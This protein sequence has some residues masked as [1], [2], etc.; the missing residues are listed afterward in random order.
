MAKIEIENLF[1]KELEADG[2][3]TLLQIFQDYQ[4]DWMHACGGKGRCTTCRVIVAKGLE[5]LSELTIAEQR[6][7]SKNLLLENERLCC[8]AKLKGNIVV[9][10]PADC[11][12][13]HIHYSDTN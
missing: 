5:N 1:G 7:R 11:K 3:K 2:Q 8:Q 10:V 13:P 4:L 12:L 9:K 6:Y